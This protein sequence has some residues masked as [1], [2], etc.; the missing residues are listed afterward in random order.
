MMLNL[1][2]HAVSPLSLR[3]CMDRGHREH[4]VRRHSEQ[5]AKRFP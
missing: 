2:P 1:K 4:F 3:E 5:L